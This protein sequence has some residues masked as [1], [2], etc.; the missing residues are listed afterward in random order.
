M[1][2]RQVHAWRVIAD[3][4][5]EEGEYMQLTGHGDSMVHVLKHAIELLVI[6]Y[7]NRMR[8]WRKK[9]QGMF[10]LFCCHCT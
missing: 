3:G 9:S 5:I 8:E 10:P 1:S 4:C 7:W 2:G 6:H